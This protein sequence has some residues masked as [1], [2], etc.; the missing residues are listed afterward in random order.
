M[1]HMKILASA[2]DLHHNHPW[3]AFVTFGWPIDVSEFEPL[4]QRKRAETKLSSSGVP[5]V[6][7][8]RPTDYEGIDGVFKPTCTFV[9]KYFV[10]PRL[11]SVVGWKSKIL[12]PRQD[13]GRVAP[14][15]YGILVGLFPQPFWRASTRNVQPHN[16]CVQQFVCRGANLSFGAERMDSMRPVL[17]SGLVDGFPLGNLT[18]KVEN[19]IFGVHACEEWPGSIRAGCPRWSYLR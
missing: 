8:Q 2:R 14:R 5:I 18:Q 7:D 6:L 10:F 19:L 16:K 15:L 11:A 13:D 17:R 4:G 1:E 12:R 3:M 9:F